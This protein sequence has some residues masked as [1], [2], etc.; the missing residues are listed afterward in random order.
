MKLTIATGAVIALDR[1][2]TSA[3]KKSFQAAR[4][5][6]MA[7]AAMPGAVKGRMTDRMV[8]PT[9]APSIHAA[10]SSETGIPSKNARISQMTSERLKVR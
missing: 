3:K 9:D 8:C 6:R 10:S 2:R 7:L 1:V 4:N 5:E